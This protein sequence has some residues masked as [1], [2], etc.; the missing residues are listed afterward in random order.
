VAAAKASDPEVTD[1]TD[2]TAE[3]A[4]LRGATNS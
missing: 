1:T 2:A 3:H 4:R